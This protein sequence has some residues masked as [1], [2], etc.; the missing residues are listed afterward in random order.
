[1][2]LIETKNIVKEYGDG[3]VTRALCGVSLKIEKGEFVAIMGS[4]GCGKST[5]MH[6]LGFL[7][8]PTF[9]Q[10]LFEGED[11]AKF[12][13]DELA[14]IRNEKIGFVFQSYNLLPRTSVFD[15]VKLPLFY[16]E[17][18]QK[19]DWLAKE[20]ISAVGLTARIDHIPGQ[21]SGGEQQRVAIARAL[22]NNPSLILA[23]EPTGNLD[24]K[25]GQQIMEILDELNGKGHT[26][27]VVTHESETAR[28]AKRILKM[29][30][31]CIIGDEKVNQRRKAGDGILK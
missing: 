4:S 29:K 27:V 1:M 31:G 13:D 25:G 14:E 24:S 9:G 7:D 12:S 10:Y 16:S 17:K 11:F 30:D 15:N 22:V 28:F 21:L 3:I 6:I 20:A 2:T 23:D 5:L 18:M 19:S 26:I 8:R